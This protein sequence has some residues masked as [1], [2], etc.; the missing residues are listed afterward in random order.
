MIVLVFSLISLTWIISENKG[1]FE[2]SEFKA[3]YGTLAEGQNTK[4]FIGTYWTIINKIRWIVTMVIMIFSRDHNIFQLMTLLFISG[5]FQTLII[6]G[7]PMQSKLENRMLFFNEIMV[8][9][10]IYILFVLS[11]FFAETNP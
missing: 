3:K 5:T 7:K 9:V 2:S 6:G 1:K 4:S 10:Y 11:D 8:S